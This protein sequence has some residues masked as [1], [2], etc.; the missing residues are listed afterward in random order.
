[1]KPV[2]TAEKLLEEADLTLLDLVDNLLDKGVMLDGEVMIGI[3]GV[4]L[5][6]LRLSAI[7]C[8]SDKILR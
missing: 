6:Y 5:V 4:D 2:T 3:A 1:M 8:A 7:L